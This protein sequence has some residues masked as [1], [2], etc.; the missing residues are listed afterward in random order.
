MVCRRVDLVIID[1]AGGFVL[2]PGVEMDRWLGGFGEV[3]HL[4]S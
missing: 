3:N 4:L 2:L 1:V